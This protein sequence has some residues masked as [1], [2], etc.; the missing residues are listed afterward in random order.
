MVASSGEHDHDET[1]VVPPETPSQNVVE[2]AV[3]RLVATMHGIET[4]Q[5]QTNAFLGPPPTSEIL[6]DEEPVQAL[7]DTGSPITIVSLDFFLKVAA[8]RRTTD[9][10]PREWGESIR[11]RLK[12]STVTLRS[13]GGD[14]LTIVSQ[15]CCQLRR[16]AKEMN[17]VLR[18][19]NGA[20]VDLLLGTDVLGRLG[21]GL[22]QQEGEGHTTDLLKQTDRQTGETGGPGHKD[23]G[24]SAVVI[25]LLQATRLPARHSRLIRVGIAN[26]RGAVE[27]MTLFEPE[28]QTLQREGYD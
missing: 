6:L 25:K 12:P 3:Q 5:T 13:Y 18:V 11:S 20:P 27:E 16:R 19:Q 2:E 17:A 1:S 8:Q 21:F 14:K 24:A 22:V 15:V 28:T 10:S 7:L 4:R 9:Q 26:D 23:A